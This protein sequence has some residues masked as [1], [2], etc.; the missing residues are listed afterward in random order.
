MSMRFLLVN[1]LWRNQFVDFIL[2]KRIVHDSESEAVQDQVDRRV[3]CNPNAM[4]LLCLSDIFAQLVRPYKAPNTAGDQC[5][6]EMLAARKTR[7][8]AQTA[9]VIRQYDEPVDPVN[10]ASDHGEKHSQPNT[11]LQAFHPPQ[12]IDTKPQK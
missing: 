1:L 4:T 6:Q 5:E 12:V 9:H 10:A 8:P 2:R 7:I 11:S 3:V